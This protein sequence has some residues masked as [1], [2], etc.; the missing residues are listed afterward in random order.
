MQSRKEASNVKRENNILR[1]SRRS[2]ELGQYLV[3]SR[4]PVWL[5]LRRKG[6]CTGHAVEHRYRAVL[7]HRG[8]CS[9][10]YQVWDLSTV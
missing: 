2:R 3:Q 1:K 10:Y 6:R 9:L 7:R 8:P 5:D 4:R